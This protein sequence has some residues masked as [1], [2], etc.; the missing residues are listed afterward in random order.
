MVPNPLNLAKVVLV[1]LEDDGDL[2]TKLK[3]IG[4]GNTTIM[5]LQVS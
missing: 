1:L 5:S 4:I 2:S 3:N